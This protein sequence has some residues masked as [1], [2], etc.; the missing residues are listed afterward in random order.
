MCIYLESAD[1]PTIVNTIRDLDR[2]NNMV[3]ILLA[4]K[5]R[6]DISALIASLNKEAINFMGGF[7]PGLIYDNSAYDKGA[8]ILIL[9]TMGSPFVIGNIDTACQL[10][11]FNPLLKQFDTDPKTAFILVDGLAAGMAELLAKIYHRLGNSVNYI[12]GGAGSLTMQQSPCVFT[13]EGCFMNTA[14]LVFLTCES[15]VEAKHGW[16][17]IMGP[18][19]ATKTRHNV[20]CELNWQNA[21]AIY[22]QVLEADSGLKLTKNNFYDTAK[23]YPFGIVK[24]QTETI[25]REAVAVNDD[26]ELVCIGTVPE[27][28]VMEI[29]KGTPSSLTA[30]VT[31]VARNCKTSLIGK[32]PVQSLVVECISRSLFLK[33]KLS[34]ELGAIKAE[35]TFTP[36]DK[37]P[38]GILSLGEIASAKDGFLEFL[39][40]TVVIGVL[41]E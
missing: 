20:I 34:D 37:V 30:S 15:Y 23:S 38:V 10:P 8:I 17:P 27:N 2:Q 16:Q 9:P 11:D 3:I 12:G 25:V 31:E 21:F 18:I 33:D 6:P 29:L 40:K 41:Y 5:E 4:E 7:F 39:N 19:V 14:V 26:D 35:L 32:K 13:P 24:E 22:Q 1:I 36:N 28:T